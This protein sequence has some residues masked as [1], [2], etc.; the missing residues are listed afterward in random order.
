MG[1]TQLSHIPGKEII[2]L[3]KSDIDQMIYTE[4]ET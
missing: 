1:A 2:S 4:K 3:H